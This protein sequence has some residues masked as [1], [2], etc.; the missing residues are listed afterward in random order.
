[1]GYQSEERGMCT[2]GSP[3]KG[4]GVGGAGRLGAQDVQLPRPPPPSR[5]FRLPI[6][7]LHRRAPPPRLSSPLRDP[8]SRQCEQR[9]AEPGRPARQ[10]HSCCHFLRGGSSVISGKDYPDGVSLQ[11][12]GG[13]VFFTN[14]DDGK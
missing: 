9:V 14:E 2:E 5:G 10:G 13:S 4:H 1:M 3:K 11:L 6:A 12:G 8:T 7:F